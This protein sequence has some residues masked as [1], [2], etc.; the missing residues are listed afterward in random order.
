MYC[1]NCCLCFPIRGGGMWLSGLVILVNAVGAIF[2]F[3]WGPFF[4]SSTQAVIFGGF[5]VLQAAL[6]GIAFFGFCSD[7]ISSGCYGGVNDKGYT[8]PTALANIYC[9]YNIDT[10]VMMFIVGFVLDFVLKGYH[11][12]VVWRYYVRMRLTPGDQKYSAFTYEE[13]LDEI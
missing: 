7:Q 12:F 1:N 6:S 8:T 11:Y 10:V 9:Q 2:L 3:L 13:A 4:F 5:S